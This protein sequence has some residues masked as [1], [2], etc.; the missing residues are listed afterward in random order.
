MKFPTKLCMNQPIKRALRTSL[1][2]GALALTGMN[3]CL[4]AAPVTDALDRPAQ[5]TELG[6]HAVL[7]GG[8]MAGKRIVVVGERGLILFSDD[9][10]AHWRQGRV[11]VSVTLTAV[12]FA[13]DTTG[14]AI[15]HAGTVLKSTDAGESWEKL[16][17]GKQVAQMALEQAKAG[18][19]ESA[20]LM[21]ER[22]VA[23]G[24]DKP[25][26]DLLVDGPDYLSVVGAYGIALR[27]EDGGETWHSWQD[28]LGND[29]GMHQ[30]AIRRNGGRVLIAGEQGLIRLSLDGGRLFKELEPPYEGSYFAAELL[31]GDEILLA[32]LRGNVWH[33]SDNG[34]TWQQLD[35]P[36]DASITAVLARPDGSVLMVNQ[37]GMVMEVRNGALVRLPVPPMPPLTNILATD[38]GEL[39]ALSVQGVFKVDLGDKK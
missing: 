24:P 15:G 2:A 29:F 11:P 20:I 4:Y 30:Y 22:L 18:G 7:L 38:T 3:T 33:S 17:D 1:I 12:R 8:A 19:E 10:G 21:A 32:G 14:Y 13:D 36:V 39:L 5:M 25:M 28:R 34:S 26:L 9:K 31:G 6:A 35:T 16:L 23:D 37:A 27:S